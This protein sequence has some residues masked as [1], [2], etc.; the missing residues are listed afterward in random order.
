MLL[1]YCCA[2][3][4][5]GLPQP[6]RAA[7]SDV[8]GVDGIDQLS[9]DQRLL[10]VSLQGLVNRDGPILWLSSGANQSPGLPDWES[11]FPEVQARRHLGYSAAL[12]LFAHTQSVRGVVIVDP[13]IEETYNI[14]TNLASQESLLIVTPST[15][16]AVDLPI[17]HDLRGR[18]ADEAAAMAANLLL[19]RQS[20]PGTAL[21]AVPWSARDFLYGAPERGRDLAIQRRYWAFSKSVD[22][23]DLVDFYRGP[24]AD[25]R[26]LYGSSL[27][28]N[29]D[30]Y[31]ASQAGKVWIGMDL[32]L[33]YNLSFFD[34]LRG[35]EN[36]MYRQ[37]PREFIP[38]VQE[39]GRDDV[40]VAF[41]M[42]EG[43]NPF[44]VINQM[45]RNW[46]DPAH[47]RIP[48]GWTIAPR[49]LDLAPAVLQYYY[50]TAAPN[51][52]FLAGTSGVAY[53]QVNPMDFS[54]YPGLLDQETPGL[55]RKLDIR[56]IRNFG[57][58]LGVQMSFYDRLRAATVSFPE[59]LGWIEGH[60]IPLPGEGALPYE[61]ATPVLLDGR[62][63][64][65][66]FSAWCD[67]DSDVD[68]S[69]ASIRA[70]AATHPGRPLQILVGMDQKQSTPTTVEAIA[71]RLGP[72]FRFVRPDV[73]YRSRPAQI[74]MLGTRQVTPTSV[75][76]GWTSDELATGT[77]RL[78]TPEEVRVQN[79]IGD[80]VLMHQI[81]IGNLSPD[82]RY[83]YTVE[84]SDTDGNITRSESLTFTTTGGLAVN[85]GQD[86][87]ARVFLVAGTII[88]LA[89]LLPLPFFVRRRHVVV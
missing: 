32:Q 38:I 31:R 70:Y 43:D 81:A 44:F 40:L 74:A 10:L 53:Y 33:Q 78:T 68:R 52:Y 21:K 37:P 66:P 16:G 27:N 17:R 69:A 20:E 64:D 76:I 30:I 60:G 86:P 75:L 87:R 3:L 82:T 39:P 73:L 80:A 6:V 56:I 22:D 29:L 71:A 36:F 46:Q 79:E 4:A 63:L 85:L 65:F 51:D 12:A 54:R 47:G 11:T 57:D 18:Y 84:V 35:Q 28:E 15:I 67:G 23:A 49:M 77:V 88:L 50:A 7:A 62:Y 59:M 5:V 1:V 25:V 72:R 42:T 13:A 55:L 24:L 9:I 58:W 14:A 45:R 61:R 8:Y 2:L 34:Q 19:Y 41:V 89:F 83:T 26:D 48:I